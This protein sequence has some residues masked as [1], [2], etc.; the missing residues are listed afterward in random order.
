M[1]GDIVTVDHSHRIGI[2][3]FE[4]PPE[5]QQ[6]YHKQS[7]DV[8]RLT[9]VDG[10]FRLENADGEG[11][12]EFPSQSALAIVTTDL[13]AKKRNRLEAWAKSVELDVAVFEHH[14]RLPYQISIIAE[15]LVRSSRLAAEAN[16]RLAELR[17]LHEELHNAYAGL[18]DYFHEGGYLL[19]RLAY[20][21]SPDPDGTVLPSSVNSFEQ[22]LPVELRSL[23]AVSLHLSRE[24]PLLSEGVLTVEIFSPD[25]DTTKHT[26]SVPYSKLQAGWNTFAF[27]QDHRFLQ[28]SAV[29]RATC[30]TETGSTPLFSMGRPL[31]RQDRAVKLDG[32]ADSRSLALKAWT[33][34]RGSRLSITSEMWPVLLPDLSRAN[35]V[36]IAI[37]ENLEVV[38]LTP[39]DNPANFPIVVR[40]L[41]MKRILVHP[42]TTMPTI[43]ELPLA[44]L[45]GTRE[46]RAEV[47]TDNELA[48]PVE[49][50][51][52]TVATNGLPV[53]GGLEDV[54]SWVD[55]QL[56][57]SKTK[58]TISCLLPKPAEA[59]LSLILLT[60]MPPGQ[61]SDYCW[62]HF[63]QIYLLG[64]FA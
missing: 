53:S 60:R 8:S 37:T 11:Y 61:S 50:A 21:N 62:S 18:R 9:E 33:S 17:Q 32:R 30:Q 40:D 64:D 13:G 59:P 41:D 36:D 3:A 22:R 48:A 55:W 27:D 26:W 46:I 57:P 23:R 49:Y 44:C 7:F 5:M 39:L 14:D 43:A 56:I 4:L 1:P 58:T 20:F 16:L 38:D 10:R 31:L 42:L 35:R 28:S 47:I 12:L 34:L 51:M 29:L 19:P 15:R 52:T 63:R 45:P 25:D 2:I 54:E 24:T 6:S